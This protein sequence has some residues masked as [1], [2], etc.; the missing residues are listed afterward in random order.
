MRSDFS[1]N[2]PAIK[3]P[4]F[5]HPPKISIDTVVLVLIGPLYNNVYSSINSSFC[6]ECLRVLMSRLIGV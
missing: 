5:L 3:L 2:N 4:V 6:H 1:L